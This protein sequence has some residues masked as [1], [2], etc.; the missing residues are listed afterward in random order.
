MTQVYCPPKDLI[1]DRTNRHCGFFLALTPAEHTAEDVGSSKYFGRLV[2]SSNLREDD[3]ITVRPKNKGF[4]LELIVRAIIPETAEVITE[5]LT[6]KEFATGVARSDGYSIEWQGDQGLHAIML[7][8]RVVEAGFTTEVHA[9][10]R[11]E[12]LAPDVEDRRAAVGK[13]TKP[14]A[15]AAKPKAAA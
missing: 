6:F 10:H 1:L 14:K 2:G 5:A 3:Q 9:R 15:R 12:K 7:D 11:L 13:T 8:G 4:H